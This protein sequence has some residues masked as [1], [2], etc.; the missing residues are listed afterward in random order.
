MNRNEEEE[1]G[2]ERMKGGD[3]KGRGM[4]KKINEREGREV[5]WKGKGR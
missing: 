3:K 1:D 4:R 2:H 5:Q